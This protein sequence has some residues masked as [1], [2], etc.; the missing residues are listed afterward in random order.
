MK[1][2]HSNGS[3]KSR[4]FSAGSRSAKMQKS[5][6]ALGE[7]FNQGGRVSSSKSRS[8]SPQRIRN[9]RK[10]DASGVKN[11]GPDL[12]DDVEYFT[13]GNLLMKSPMKGEIDT[14]IN[15]EIYK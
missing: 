15:F 11:K 13:S 3:R 1:R 5:N 7:R 8:R 10:I 6:S 4:S 2:S 14:R 9:Q 12:N